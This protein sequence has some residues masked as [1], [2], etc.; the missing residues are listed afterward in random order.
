MH[1]EEIKAA[2]RMNG[3]TAARLA[4]ELEL[5]PTTISMVV[6]GRGTSKRVQ[7]RISEII[8]KPYDEVFPP[9][10]S[11]LRRTAEELP[12]KSA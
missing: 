9:K 5:N 11:L 6:N 10:P 2:M 4:E 8:G 7:K 1:P 3:V 12:R